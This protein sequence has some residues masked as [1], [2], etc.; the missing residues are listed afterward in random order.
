MSGITLYEVS[1][2]LI[3]LLDSVDLCETDEQRAQCEAEIRRAMDVQIHKVDSFCRFLAHVESQT[4]LATREIERLKAREAVFENLMQRLKAYAVFTMQQ[5]RLRKLEG[6]TSKL[7]LRTNQAAV[8]ID[9]EQLV[10]G[11]FKTIKQVVSVDRR[12]IKNAIDGGEVVPGARLREPSISL[13][14]S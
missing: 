2:T 10:P 7:T 13:L 9:D 3:A 6:D 12:A 11:K 1:E 8:D 14:R 4:E 5:M